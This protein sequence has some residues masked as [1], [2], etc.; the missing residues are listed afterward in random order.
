[1]WTLQYSIDTLKKLRLL[2]GI[3]A[4][5]E[6]RAHDVLVDF[7]KHHG[8]TVEPHYKLETAFRA[9]WQVGDTSNNCGCPGGICR[10]ANVALLCEYDALPSIGHGC[11][12][13][14]IAEVGAGAAVG[15]KAALA[16]SGRSV[17]KVLV[18]FVSL[19]IVVATTFI[20]SFANQL[21]SDN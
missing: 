7:F 14:L 6:K 17:G 16:A 3:F 19:D 8:F 13:N 15:V 12:H 9:T 1:V 5:Q 18:Q 11:G 21:T 10:P 20:R 4:L 2:A